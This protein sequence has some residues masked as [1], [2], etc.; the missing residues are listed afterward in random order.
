MLAGICD[1]NI[2]ENETNFLKVQKRDLQF[3]INFPQ[4]EFEG[5]KMYEKVCDPKRLLIKQLNNYVNFV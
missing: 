2:L 1:H 3:L 5:A 4:S